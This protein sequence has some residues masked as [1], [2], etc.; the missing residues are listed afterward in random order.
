MCDA[1]SGKFLARKSVHQLRRLTLVS[2]PQR[3][4]PVSS[5]S[6]DTP[7][8]AAHL[9]CIAVRTSTIATPEVKPMTASVPVLLITGPVGVGKSTVAAEAARLLREAN[10]PHAL[11]D[12][13]WIEQCWPVPTDD[14]WNERLTHRNLACMWANFRQAGADRL[15]LVRVLEARS[16]LRQVVEAVPGAEVT[17]VRLRAPLAVLQARI[18]SREASDPSWFLGAATH[19]AEV[20]E[21][22]GVEDHLVDNQ[23]RP[24]AAVAEEVLRR[25]GWLD[26]SAG[27]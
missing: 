4:Q 3:G 8:L 14:P 17:V 10:V 6:T 21:R 20:L 12:L 22:A 16:L 18:R 1:V 24:V 15:L 19:T 25:V 7:K 11:V 9:W 27:A 26:L 23:D 5:H 13:A 2:S